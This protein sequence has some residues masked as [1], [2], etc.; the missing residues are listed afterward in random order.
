MGSAYAAHEENLRGS[1]EVGK[2]GDLVVWSENMYAVP[3]DK[4]RDLKVELAI[5]AGKVVYR[6]P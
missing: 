1:I 4:I 6:R 2:R 5:V 3:T